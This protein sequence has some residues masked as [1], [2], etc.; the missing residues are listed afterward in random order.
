MEFLVTPRDR[1]AAFADGCVLIICPQ[2]EICLTGLWF[3][4]MCLP[5]I[6]GLLS[7]LCFQ[8]NP[9][10]VPPC[11]IAMQ[12]DGPRTLTKSAADLIDRWV[13]I[14][15]PVIENLITGLLIKHEWLAL[16]SS[17]ICEFTKAFLA[18]DK[19]LLI[20]SVCSQFHCAE[21]FFWMLN[22][23][24]ITEFSSDIQ[25]VSLILRLSLS[26]ISIISYTKLSAPSF[27]TWQLKCP[28]LPFLKARK[29]ALFRLRQWK[30]LP[31]YFFPVKTCVHE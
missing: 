19:A 2:S 8:R 20:S 5:I 10:D 25:N 9:P 26:Q 30:L 22:P 13:A 28:F 24:G 15:S 27:L 16:C 17:P 18:T 23:F 3:D 12:I 29:C 6:S 14:Y 4:P 11:F 7:D 1:A 21:G 31:T